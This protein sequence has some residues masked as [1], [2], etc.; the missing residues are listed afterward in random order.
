MWHHRVV[1]EGRLTVV[2]AP[3]TEAHFDAID[4][5]CVD[6]ILGIV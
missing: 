3:V 2:I 1:P 4:G 5:L 6:L